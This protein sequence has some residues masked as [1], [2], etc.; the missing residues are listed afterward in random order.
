VGTPERPLYTNSN[1]CNPFQNCG[2]FLAFKKKEREE[3][4]VSTYE[5]E[6]EKFAFL[7]LRVLSFRFWETVVGVLGILF[8]PVLLNGAENISSFI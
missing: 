5:T 6:T 1:Y 3:G 2:K 4:F 7:L 8:G